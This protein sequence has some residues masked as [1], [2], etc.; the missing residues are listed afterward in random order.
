MSRRLTRIKDVGSR[1]NPIHSSVFG[2]ARYFG[3][4]AASWLAMQATY[5]LKT[6]PT[7]DDIMRRV[8]PRTSHG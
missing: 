4:D 6:L 5:D 2:L 7:L 3:G 8:I 1:I